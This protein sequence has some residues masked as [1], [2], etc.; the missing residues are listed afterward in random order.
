MRGHA[1]TGNRLRRATT[2]LLAV[3]LTAGS[4]AA[5]PTAQADSTAAATAKKKKKC[6][7]GFVR[8]KG[9]CR[10]KK[11]PGTTTP[12][13]TAP[14]GTTTISRGPTT[15]SISPTS[16]DFGTVTPEE[17]SDAQTF[18]VTNTGPNPAGPMTYTTE[19]ENGDEF[20]IRND[21][22]TEKT[23]LPGGTCT[24][25]VWFASG[26][27]PG[28]KSGSLRINGPLATPVSASLSGFTALGLPPP[29]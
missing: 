12:V 9:K 25:D 19:G 18:T 13:T 23:L 21:F 1:G 14:V 6:K 15:L 8:K 2:L 5:L 16:H 22:C 27:A 10:R 11:S 3:A 29:P 24:L 17:H 26:L 28:P 4:V 7:K 20:H